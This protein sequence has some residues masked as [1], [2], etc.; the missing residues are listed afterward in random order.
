M[1]QGR[2]RPKRRAGRPL[3]SPRT[4]AR[5][6][7]TAIRCRPVWPRAF[8]RLG[9]ARESGKRAGP[10]GPPPFQGPPVRVVCTTT[11][12]ADVVQ[13]VGGDRVKVETLM[14]AN[15]DPHRYLAS[16][17]DTSRMANAHLDINRSR[18]FWRDSRRLL[19]H[20]IS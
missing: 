7:R 2:R 4:D 19:C 14:R 10:E 3:T 11:L 5:A 13:R 16:A 9:F 8:V 1:S 20:E 18:D 6:R 12:V 15:V 17:G